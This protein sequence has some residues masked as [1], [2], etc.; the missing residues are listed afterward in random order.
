MFLLGMFEIKIDLEIMIIMI[1]IMN[2]YSA[3]TIKEYSK[4]LYIKLN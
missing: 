1:V 3:K 4:A 2:L